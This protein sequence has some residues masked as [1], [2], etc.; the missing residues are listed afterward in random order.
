MTLCRLNWDLYIRAAKLIP[1]SSSTN[2]TNG[3]MLCKRVFTPELP[4]PVNSMLSGRDCALHRQWRQHRLRWSRCVRDLTIA[5]QC[6]MALLLSGLNCKGVPKGLGLTHPQR[7]LGNGAGDTAK[8]LRST[9]QGGSG[10]I[11]REDCDLWAGGLR[12]GV[13]SRYAKRWRR[14]WSFAATRELILQTL[15][16]LPRRGLVAPRLGSVRLLQRPYSAG[17]Y[18]VGQRVRAALGRY[19]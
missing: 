8:P 18:K 7:H 2:T 12:F 11:C 10:Q 4:I 19:P 17:R 5:A 9:R 3:L 16:N 15:A 6:S 1:T 14:R 13:W